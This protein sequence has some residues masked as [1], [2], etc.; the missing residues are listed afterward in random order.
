MGTP[1]RLLQ[2]AGHEPPERLN[3][4]RQGSWS[5]KEHIGHLI[6][7]QDR[8]E[9][10][11]EDIGQRRSQLTQVDLTDQEHF[12]AGHGRREMGDLIEEFR[13][14][15]IYFSERIMAMG[16]AELLHRAAHPCTGRWMTPADILYFLAEHDDHHLALMR[17]LLLASSEVLRDHHR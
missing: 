7:V 17:Q 9:P 12:V 16:Q 8:M 14:K 5:V 13:L 1:A 10:R 15:R 11:L 4:R 6:L 2:L 3:L